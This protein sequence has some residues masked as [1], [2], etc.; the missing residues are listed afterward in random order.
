M[1][2]NISVIERLSD[3]VV[4]ESE[5]RAFLEVT[6]CPGLYIIIV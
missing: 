1:S 3:S 4:V 6:D 5:A 2:S